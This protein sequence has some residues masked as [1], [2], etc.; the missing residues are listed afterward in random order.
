MEIKPTQTTTH[1]LTT[2]I[3]QKPAAFAQMMGNGISGTVCFYKYKDGTLMIYEIEGL[4]KTSRKEG[5]IFGFHIHEG[6]TCLNN[7]ATPFEK[8]LGHLNPENTQHP[9]HLGDLPPLFA[10]KGK[11]WSMVYLDKFI[12]ADIMGRT[13]VIHQH[14]DDFHSQPSGQSGTRIACGDIKVFQ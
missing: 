12:P 2:A 14:P 6:K 11:A 10:T 9:Y 5:G 4:P 3:N 13:V 1:I 8:T 7:T